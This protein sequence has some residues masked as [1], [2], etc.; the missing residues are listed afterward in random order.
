MR[1]YNV[2]YVG[3]GTVVGGLKEDCDAVYLYSSGTVK[4]KELASGATTVVAYGGAFAPLYGG[5]VTVKGDKLVYEQRESA[6]TQ[7][8][9]A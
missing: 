8:G 1:F 6:R 7:S 4:R 9:R 3:N 2:G 5:S